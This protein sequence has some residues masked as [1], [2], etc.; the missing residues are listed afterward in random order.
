MTEPVE[1]RQHARVAFFLIPVER[2]QV[3]YWVFVPPTTAGVAGVVVNMSEGGIQVL[4][5]AESPLNEDRYAISLIVE[6]TAGALAPFQGTV[7]RIWTRDLNAIEFIH[8]MQ[9]E[10]DRSDAAEFLRVIRPGFEERRWVRCSLSAPV[11]RPC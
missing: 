11:S 7:R 6:P 4:T 9:F 5:K 1:R 10:D 8:G 3:P 2:E